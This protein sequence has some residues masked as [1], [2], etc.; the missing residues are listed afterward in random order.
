MMIAPN[1][2]KPPKLAPQ[3]MLGYVPDKPENYLRLEALRMA[4]MDFSLDPNAPTDKII[5]R[6]RA[7]EAYLMETANK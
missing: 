6:A 7:Y 2:V 1:L 4:R 5:A 3:P